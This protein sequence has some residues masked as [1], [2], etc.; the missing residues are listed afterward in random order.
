MSN[1]HALRSNFR[2]V[3]LY[4][5]TKLSSYVLSV[6]ASSEARKSEEE[7][8]AVFIAVSMIVGFDIKARNAL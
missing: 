4:K 3:K 6:I 2:S 8:V 1:K 5:D 7:S